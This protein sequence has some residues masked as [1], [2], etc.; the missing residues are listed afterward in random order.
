MARIMR[1]EAGPSPPD[2]PDR[3][4]PTDPVLVYAKAMIHDYLEGCMEGDYAY[5]GDL[6]NAAMWFEHLSVSDETEAKMTPQLARLLL[7]IN[8][9]GYDDPYRGG[10]YRSAMSAAQR[11]LNHVTLILRTPDDF[12]PAPSSSDEKSWLII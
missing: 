10:P 4:G 3:S 6:L 8:E 7:V 1:A 2:K 12:T 11:A 5:P 9:S